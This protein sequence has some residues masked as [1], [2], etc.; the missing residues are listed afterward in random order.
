MAVGSIL[1][2]CN[3]IG[4]QYFC[5]R[6]NPG[7]GLA[8]DLPFFAKVGL[9]PTTR[10]SRRRRKS[11]QIP[12]RHLYCILSSR[13]PNEVGVNIIGTCSEKAGLPLK[14]HALQV[15]RQNKSNC[16]APFIAKSINTQKN[17][18]HLS[19]LCESLTC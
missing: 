3:L 2:Y 11:G 13:V 7:I 10:L 15:T 5:S 14:H 4:L 17:S 8:P 6:T 1:K 12:I 18:R 16:A 9:H 19:S